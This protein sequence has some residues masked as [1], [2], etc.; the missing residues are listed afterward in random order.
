MQVELP[1]F[2][3]L[4][5]QLLDVGCVEY[6]ASSAR[7][8]QQQLPEAVA[9]LSSE[10]APERDPKATL[11]P[12]KNLVRQE[13]PQGAFE[14]ILRRPVAQPELRRNRGGELY[15]L[16]IEQRDA[17]LDGMRHAHP[18][19]F[20]Q[21]VEREVALQIQGL[22]PGEPVAV[23]VLELFSFKTEGIVMGESLKRL[24]P[25]QPLFVLES[26][27]RY[28]IQA[29]FHLRQREMPQEVSASH[30]LGHQSAEQAEQAHV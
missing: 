8:R 21:D 6:S 23:S 1:S 3:V 11:G 9:E 27:Q 13:S 16:V 4:L 28:V 26:E 18:V 2:F 5:H 29:P 10:P 25:E 12:V 24:F 30:A 17:R 19:H 15:E 14:D 22:E 20:G 7:L